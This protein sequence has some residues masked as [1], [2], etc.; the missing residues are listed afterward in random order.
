M[1]MMTKPGRFEVEAGVK[2]PEAVVEALAV[3]PLRAVRREGSAESFV[4]PETL[5]A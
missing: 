4:H 5:L 2:P 3:R 1:A